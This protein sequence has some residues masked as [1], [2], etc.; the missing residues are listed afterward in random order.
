LYRA[1]KKRFVD[2]THLFRQFFLRR[3]AWDVSYEEYGRR[4]LIDGSAVNLICPILL[5]SF[6]L[7][8][9]LKTRRPAREV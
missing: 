5:V 7:R 9:A 1:N 3:V 4:M 6:I 8:E 2:C